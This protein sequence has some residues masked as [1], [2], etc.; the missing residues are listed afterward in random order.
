MP[1]KKRIGNREADC[2][3]CRLCESKCPT[4]IKLDRLVRL[5]RYLENKR[6][7][8][9]SMFLTMG[10]LS[11]NS[12]WEYNEGETSEESDIVFFPG[13]TPLYDVAFKTVEEQP[14]GNYSSMGRERKYSQIG[15]AGLKLLNKLEIKPRMV[16]VCC[17]HDQYY[18]GMLDDVEV[19]SLRL[20]EAIGNAKLIVTPCAEC[21]HMLADVHGLPAVHISE[22]LAERGDDLE[23]ERTG[24][25]VMYHDP[26]R[27][28]RVSGVYDDPRDLISMAADLS[29]FKNNREEAIC[30]GVSSWMNC[31]RASKEQRERKIEEFEDSG[32]DYLVVSCPKC[33]MH[34]DCLYSE[35]GEEGKE[36]D[37]PN[38]IDISEL[39]AISA[40]I[41]SI[42]ETGESHFRASNKSEGIVEC[43]RVNKD[44]IKHIDSDLTNDLFNCSTCF[45]CVEICETGHLTPH[46][47]EELRSFFISK[48]MNPE[49]HRKM[50][51]SIAS[52]G[53]PFGEGEG[54]S[55]VKDGA[56]FIYFPGCTGVYRMRGIF[57]GTKKILDEMNVSYTIPEGLECCGSPLM[58]VGYNPEQLKAR[59][60]EALERKVLVSCAGCHA[61]LANDYDGV[62]VEHIIELLARNVKE[63]NLKPLKMKVAYHDPCHL[64]REFGIYDEPREVIKAIPGVELV[65]FSEN[66]EKSRCCGGGGGLRSWNPDKAA[67]LARDR[68]REA[69]ERGVDAVV[70]ACPFCKLNLQ[71][72]TDLE[73]LDIIEL[74]VRSL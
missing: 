26:C 11:S 19:Q 17:G 36:R 33:A 3:S 46:L 37:G 27:L 73:V 47:M 71:A 14:Y 51:S 30:C 64:G 43:R 52:T 56:E 10:L 15:L 23:L 67:E 44:P 9:G 65:E 53:N 5:H 12:S 24:L 54:Y 2:T 60:A 31:N 13:C 42:E 32:A 1:M 49:K 40:G 8:H 39:L 63:M 68:M 70:S 35:E 29:E 41:H 20:K 6:G 18:A 50:L 25:K 59:N 69:E 61:A 22:F 45:Q 72:V 74:L 34:L 58:R 16:T 55:Q 62:E 57:E 66:R 48:E 38:I 28:G 21:R 7:S 4:E